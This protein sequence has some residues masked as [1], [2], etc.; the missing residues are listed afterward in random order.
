[1]STDQ[2]HGDTCRTIFLNGWEISERI[3]WKTMFRHLVTNPQVLVKNQKQQRR[4]KWYW[5]NTVFILSS[6]RTEIAKHAGEPQVQGL[7]AGNALVMPYR[8]LKKLLT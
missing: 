2:E 3:W 7:F 6:R 5:E 4:K 8:E 1:M